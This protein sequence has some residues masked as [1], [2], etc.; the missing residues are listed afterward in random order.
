MTFPEQ[1]VAIIVAAGSSTRM[2]ADKIWAELAGAPV[3]AHS[4]AALASTPGVTDIV[5]VAPAAKH[6]AIA[7][8][9]CPVPIVTVEGGA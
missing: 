3:I 4:I 9:P 5:V 6:E 8:L 1:I 7:L 2:G